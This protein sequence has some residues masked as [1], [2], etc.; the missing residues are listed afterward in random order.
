MCQFNIIVT[1]AVK[2][3][4]RDNMTSSN[5]HVSGWRTDLAH[6]TTHQTEQRFKSSHGYNKDA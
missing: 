3:E 1:E 2:R 5:C 6:I 4:R